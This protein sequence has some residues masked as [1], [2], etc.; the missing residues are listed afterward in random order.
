VVRSEEE[1]QESVARLQQMVAAREQEH[2]A[3]R[4]KI[5]KLQ[6]ELS[7]KTEGLYRVLFLYQTIQILTSLT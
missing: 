2:T 7:L 1:A 3:A 4:M 5:E 6:V